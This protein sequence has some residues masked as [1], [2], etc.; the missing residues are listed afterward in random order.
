[1][2]IYNGQQVDFSSPCVLSAAA[3]N[4]ERDVMLLTLLRRN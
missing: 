4:K 2:N 1:M 3:D